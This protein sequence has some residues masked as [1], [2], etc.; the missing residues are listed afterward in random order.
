[1]ANKI[2]RYKVENCVS[3]T[4]CAHIDNMLIGTHACGECQ[5][6]VDIN[7]SEY[8]QYIICSFGRKDEV[9]TAYENPTKSKEIG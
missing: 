4:K 1:M 8:N 6:F 2:L 9:I 3:A 7:N 5:C